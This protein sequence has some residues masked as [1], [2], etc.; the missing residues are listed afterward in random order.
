M[1][2]LKKRRS[3]PFKR[4]FVACLGNEKTQFIAIPIFAILLS[5][6]AASIVLLVLGKNP[7]VAFQSLLQGSGILPKLSYA[8]KKSQLTDFMSMLNV[9][10][11]MI[12]AAMAVAVAFKTGLFNIGVSGQM[13]VAG[14]VS[15][16]T[17]GYSNLPMVAAIPLA[18][19]IGVVCGALYGA[20]IG[21][22]KHKF[23][24]NE[25]V[26]SIMLNYIAQ[27]FI[28]YFIYTRYINSVTRQ[29][30]QISDA[31]RLTLADFEI[32]GLKMDIPLGFLLTIPLV[33]LVRYLMDRTRVGYELKVVG[34][35]R[36]AARYAGIKVGRNIV[37]A[38]TISGALAGLAGVTYY[39]G[40]QANIQPKVLSD[41]GFDSIAVSLLGN[42]SPIGIL[43]ASL[44]IT[45]ISKGSN[46]MSSMVNVPQEIS[47]VITGLILLFSACGAYIR[48]RVSI[49]KD[50]LINLRT[51]HDSKAAG[52][53]GGEV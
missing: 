16:I 49:S 26:T 24:I 29:S 23:N 28:S 40:Y 19:V 52:E 35:N 42:S 20:L 46:Y 2:R 4:S 53:G 3:N 22:L 38:M 30:R 37:L 36:R 21:W 12:F 7:L 17:V 31:A 34:L 51:E 18:I 27:Y 39:M 8:A 48:Y 11:P 14:F 43:F 9:L 5:L 44:L 6:L 45:I 10:T 13:L 41:M 33:F 32:F 47:Q 50:D 15:S 1:N 25:V